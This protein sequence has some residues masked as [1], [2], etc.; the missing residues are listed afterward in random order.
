MNPEIITHPA[1]PSPVNLYTD[2]EACMLKRIL[3]MGTPSEY[4]TMLEAVRVRYVLQD[5]YNDL[6]ANNP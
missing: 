5:N 3:E 2:L 6:K 4:L 1:A